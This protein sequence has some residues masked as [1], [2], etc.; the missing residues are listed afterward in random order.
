MRKSRGRMAIAIPIVLTAAIA[1]PTTAFAATPVSSSAPT[2][3]SASDTSWGDNSTGWV[4]KITDDVSG[5]VADLQDPWPTD[6]VDTGK[7]DSSIMPGTIGTAKGI[8]SAVDKGEPANMNISYYWADKST[9][10]L[11]VQA[12]SDGTIHAQCTVNS[13]GPRHH[14][15][16]TDPGSADPIGVHLW[17]G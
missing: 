16:V 7:T 13:V 10:Q 3:V 14:C 5:S 1:A 11:A 6:N 15:D 4:V 12:D 2:T 8:E 17:V 9:I